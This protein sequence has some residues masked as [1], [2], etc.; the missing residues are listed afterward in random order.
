MFFICNLQLIIGN[1]SILGDRSIVV[2]VMPKSFQAVNHKLVYC[3]IP[4][5]V[6][7]IMMGVMCFLHDPQEFVDNNKTISGERWRYRFK[8]SLKF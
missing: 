8:C 4:K 2:H 5:D 1:F 3:A 7:T 6:C